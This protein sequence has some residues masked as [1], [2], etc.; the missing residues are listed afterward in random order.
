ML[1]KVIDFYNNDLQKY[2]RR[3]RPLCL[4]R[5]FYN[6][7]LKNKNESISHADLIK[8]QPVKLNY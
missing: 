2:Q 7:E 8:F 4:E 6:R 5:Y 3:F 1:K